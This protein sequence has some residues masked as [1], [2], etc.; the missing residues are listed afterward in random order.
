L[1][2]SDQGLLESKRSLDNLYRLFKLFETSSLEQ[3]PSDRLG[4]HL[5]ER[6]AEAFREAMDDDF[7]TPAAIAEFQRL[8]EELNKLLGQGLSRNACEEARKTFQKYGQV[9]GLFQVEDW[10]FEPLPPGASIGMSPMP[11]VMRWHPAYGVTIYQPVMFPGLIDEAE[12]KRKDE[13]IQRKLDERHKARQ[14]KDFKRADEI[15]AELLASYGITIEDRPDG[16]SR[17]K[18]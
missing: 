14:R 6:L 16:T 4:Q 13:E 1:D 5:L 17:W 15:R 9:L 11:R 3:G 12:R 18:R 10:Q 7:N 8:H 2:F